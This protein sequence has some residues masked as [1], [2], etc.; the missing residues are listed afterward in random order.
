MTRRRIALLPRLGIRPSVH[1]LVRDALDE[2]ISELERHP[3]REI[4]VLDAGCGRKS[5]IGAFQGR[6]ARVVG[7]DIHAPDRMPSFVDDF[8]Q[9]DLCGPAGAFDA[10]SFDLVLS[11]F[12]LEHFRDPD[13]ALANFHAW[14]GRDGTLVASTVNHRNPWVRAYLGLPDGVRARLQPV[15]KAS[16]HD[17][18]PLVGAC[19]DPVAIRSALARAG[20]HDVRL[21]TVG[22][23]ARSWG[24]RLPTYVLG[25]VG[26]LLTQPFPSRRSTIVVVARA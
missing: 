21:R 22:H 5:V 4:R 19:N 15:V 18:H 20:F 13:A 17:A 9:A 16:A 3:G 12:T 25:L 2:A 23:L 14:L 24:R 11:T 6:V 8:V 10:A 26:D 7:A 1:D